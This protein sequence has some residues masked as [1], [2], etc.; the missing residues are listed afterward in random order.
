MMSFIQR[1]ASR[2]H[3]FLKFASLKSKPYYTSTMDQSFCICMEISHLIWYIVAQD[4]SNS[5]ESTMSS[6]VKHYSE[7]I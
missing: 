7:L 3:S 6:D 2:S 1:F 4:V 5:S